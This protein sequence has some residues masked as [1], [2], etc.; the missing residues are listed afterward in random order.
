[1]T[2]K[3]IAKGKT[4]ELEVRLPFKQG[5]QIS[6]C[7]ESLTGR[8]VAGSPTTIHEVM[9]EAPHLKAEAV[10]DL[11]RAIESGKL[12]VCAEGVFDE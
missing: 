2:Y 12:A 5:Q 1:M 10:D 11:E 8:R 6:V 7:V 3:G 9:H 4:I